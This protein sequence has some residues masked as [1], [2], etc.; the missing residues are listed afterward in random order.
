MLEFIR[1]PKRRLGVKHVYHLYMIRVKKRDDLL[2]YLRQNEVEA[3]VH[4]PI[5]VH[6]QHA[7]KYLA[8]KSGDFP[9]AEEDSR[10]IITLPAHQHLTNDEIDYTIQKVR[11]FYLKQ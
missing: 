1:V 7:A 6:L 8:Y 2:G 5:P 9:K 10:T 3:K 11:E 4:Y